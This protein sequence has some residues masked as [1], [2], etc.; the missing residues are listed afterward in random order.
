[1]LY[2]LDLLS[3]ESFHKHAEINVFLGFL[4]F[5]LG[6]LTWKVIYILLVDYLMRELVF[7]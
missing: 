6:S 7:S 1:M 3:M 2:A 5:S 4:P